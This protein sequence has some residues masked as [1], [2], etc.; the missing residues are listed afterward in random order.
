MLSDLGV[1]SAGLLWLG[2]LFGVALLGDRRP[3]IFA[4]H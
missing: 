3:Q 1:I 2:L 4:R